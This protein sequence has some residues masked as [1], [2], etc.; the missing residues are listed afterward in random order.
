MCLDRDYMYSVFYSIT[1]RDV[2]NQYQNT[3]IYSHV[4]TLYCDYA[5]LFHCGVLHMY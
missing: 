2:V 3:E 4:N 1:Q 5:N